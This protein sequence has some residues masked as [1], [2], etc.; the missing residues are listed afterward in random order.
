MTQKTE[1]ACKNCKRKLEY[2][3]SD[4]REFVCKGVYF[5]AL[6][7][8]YKY[9]NIIRSLLLSFKFSN[10]SYLYSLLAQEL[11]SRIKDFC[12]SKCIKIDYIISVPISYQRYLERGYNQSFL[13]A[14]AV[15]K[16]IDVPL[17]RFCLIKIKHNKRQSELNHSL[18]VANT[19]GVY[20]ITIK[21]IIKNKTILLIDDIYTTGATINECS[22]LLKE[23]GAKCVIA[24][25]CAKA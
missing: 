3:K 4:C 22:R 13:L 8:S 12:V 19:Q 15:S 5:D 21:S 23:A 11:K 10:K 24:G 14:K 25:V 2:Y 16:H 20:T 7:F 18:R 17:I 1:F 6:I 9:Q